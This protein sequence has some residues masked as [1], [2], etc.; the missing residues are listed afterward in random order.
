TD[1]AD[2]GG[3]SEAGLRFDEPTGVCQITGSEVSGSYE[4]NVR[5][6]SSSGVLTV[7]IFDSR[8]EQNQVGTGGNGITVIGSGTADVLLIVGN[9]SVVGENQAAGILTTFTDSA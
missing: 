6:T 3:G 9:G 8:I 7:G 1:N 2:T 4:D 5:I